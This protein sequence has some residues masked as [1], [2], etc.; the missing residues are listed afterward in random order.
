MRKIVS[1][2]FVALLLMTSLMAY[3]G[4]SDENFVHTLP[5]D[6]VD[7]SENTTFEVG[8][9]RIDCNH[10]YG[11]VYRDRVEQYACRRYV[12]YTEI[13][14]LECG[15]FLRNENTH[16]GTNAEHKD[17]GYYEHGELFKENGVWYLPTYCPGCGDFLGN[18]VYRP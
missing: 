8:M 10:T 14:C 3:A 16:Y 9:P 13:S 2:L 12:E 4:G 15:A 6:Y 7:V 17:Y 18:S 1:L 11:E 5:Q